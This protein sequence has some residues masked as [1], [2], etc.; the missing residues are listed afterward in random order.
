MFRFVAERVAE[1]E[2]AGFTYSLQSLWPI[3]DQNAP[4]TEA[5]TAGLQ[6]VADNPRELLQRRDA[7]RHRVLYGGLRR[8]GHRA[9]LC[10]LP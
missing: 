7:G 9:G 5:E 3:N 4:R 10:H 8:Y 6:F 2:A 1:N